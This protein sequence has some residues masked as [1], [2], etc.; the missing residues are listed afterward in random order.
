MLSSLCMMAAIFGFPLREAFV[1]HPSREEPAGAISDVPVGKVNRCQGE[2]LQVIKQKLLEA[3]NLGREPQVSRTGLGR[4]R[5]QWKAVLG[6]TAHS[7]P[8]SQESTVLD[9]TSTQESTGTRDETNST[10]LQCCQLASQ[11]F[12]NDLGWENW[13]I[14]P[15]TFTY[16]QCAVC[17]PHLDP[18]AP[19]C[20]ANSPPEP[21]T[22]SKCC[23]PTSHVMV[24]FFY[25]DE[26]N[27]PVISSVALTNQCGCK[28]GSYI[29]DAQ[30]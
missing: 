21:N 12:I 4:F 30:N 3:L 15:D 7:S 16:T 6:D 17:D 29:Q 5:E 22:P 24:P 25:L 1:L 2:S 28:P 11:I 14:F 9:T 18:K 13:I 26:L 10:G 27:T 23:Q 19:K 20:R 8:K